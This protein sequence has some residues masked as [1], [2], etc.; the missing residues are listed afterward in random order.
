VHLLVTHCAEPGEEMSSITAPT[1]EPWRWAEEY[2]ASDLATL[3][4]PEV[5]RRIDDLGIRLCA[6]GDA[7]FGEEAA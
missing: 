1:S 7:S 5:R 4:D 2:R 6:V 3:T